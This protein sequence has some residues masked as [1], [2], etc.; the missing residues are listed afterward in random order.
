MVRLAGLRRAGG[1]LPSLW[2]RFVDG[3]ADGF[4]PFHVAFVDGQLLDVLIGRRLASGR[5]I[6]VA[7]GVYSLPGQPTTVHR[8]LWIAYLAA[9]PEAVVSHWSGGLGRGEVLRVGDREP[10]IV[11][12]EPPTF[13]AFDKK[14]GEVVWSTPLPIG[15]SA[16]PMTYMY[17]GRQY[18]VIAAGGGI[19]AE[20]IAFALR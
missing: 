3:V 18:V 5:W 8:S 14:T 7:P 4:K 20:L 9:P 12:A 6:R 16:A 10:S 15:P 17:G 1:K 19:Q 13:R 2:R 11:P